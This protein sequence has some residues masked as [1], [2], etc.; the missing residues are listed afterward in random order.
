MATVMV[1]AAGA[2]PAGPFAGSYRNTRMFVREDWRVALRGLAPRPGRPRRGDP[3]PREHPGGH[4]ERSLLLL[5]RDLGLR[6]IPRPPFGFPGAWYQV[7]AGQLHL[8]EDERAR[9]TFRG[10]PLDARDI[11]FAIRVRSYREALESRR[12]RGTGPTRR[13]AI[14]WSS[15]AIRGR[16]PGS[17]RSTSWTRTGTWSR[18]TRSGSTRNERGRP[19]GPSGRPG[20]VRMVSAPLPL[21]DLAALA[22]TVAEGEARAG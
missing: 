6:E 7:G 3:A 1:W 22:A 2:G 12:P 14:P 18:S 15:G 10:K 21:D 17:R 5:R 11:H 9:A 19:N 13:R 20:T 8:I 16:P 4:V